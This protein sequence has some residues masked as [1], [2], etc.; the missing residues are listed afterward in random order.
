[1]RLSIVLITYNSGD[2][3]EGM[4]RSVEGLWDELLVGDGGST[5]GTVEMVNKYGGKII[6]QDDVGSRAK[7]GMTTQTLGVR[8]QELVERAKGDWILVLDADERVSVDLREEIKRLKDRKTVRRY[9]AYR[10]PYQN[11]VFGKPVY[12]GGERYAKVRFFR[13]GHGRISPDALHE[14]VMIDSSGFNNIGDLQG[15]IHH[16]SYRTPWQLVAK[17]TKYAW[18]AAGMIRQKQ[19]P[20]FEQLFLFGPHMVWARYVKDKGYR[21][22]WRG[23]VLALAFGYMESLTYWSLLIT[24]ITK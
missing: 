11:Y 10:I 2:V 14:E 24:R 23:L 6:E 22:G 7:P 18:V 15:V 1:M 19:K 8:K 3:V 16:H 21:D 12:W 9:D 4:L 5:D 13:R 20:G 17:F